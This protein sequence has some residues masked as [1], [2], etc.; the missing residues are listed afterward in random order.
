MRR[1]GRY[2]TDTI[3]PLSPDREGEGVAAAEAQ[4]DDTLFGIAADDFIEQCD[5]NASA[6]GSDWVAKGDRAAVDVD[7]ARARFSPFAWAGL[8]HRLSSAQPASE[9]GSSRRYLPFE[10]SAISGM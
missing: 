4:G 10:L 7:L 9:R 2:R 6:A 5:Q 1:A 8:L 3:N